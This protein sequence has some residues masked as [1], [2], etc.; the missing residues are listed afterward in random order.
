[1]SVSARLREL[2]ARSVA[3]LQRLRKLQPR[4]AALQ[5]SSKPYLP[6]LAGKLAIAT[7]LLVAFA[8]GAMSVFG[9]GSLRRLADA[10]GLTRVELAVSSARE[11]VRQSTEDLLQA[12]RILGER[13]ALQRELRGP[14]VETVPRFLG[15]Y[16]ESVALD[17]CAVVRGDEVLAA[18]TTAVD[19]DLVLAAGREQGERFLVTG[20]MESLAL[21]GALAGVA[22]HPG[23]TVVAL[24]ALDAELAARLTERTG[25]EIHI[26]DYVSFQPGEGPLAILNTDALSRGGAVAGYIEELDA[27][28][29]SL[30]VA[31][32]SGETIALLEARLP[33]AVVLGV[34][35]DITSRILFVA[36][37]IAAMAM[38]ISVYVGRYWISAVEGLTDAAERLA[39]GDLAASIPVGGG[40]ELTVLGNTM[41]LMRSNLVELTADLRR[42]EAEAKAVL[43]GIVEGVYAVDEERRVTFV[44]PQAERLLKISAA[45]ATGRFCGD[46][47]KPQLDAH[48]R[49]PCEHSCPILE[50][51]RGGS[52]RAV[53]QVAP[54]GADSPRRVVIASAPPSADGLQVQVLRDE[55]ELEAARRTRDTV[56]ANISHELRTPL[57]AQLASIELLRDGVGTMNVDGQRELVSSL[58]RGTQRLAWLIDNLLESVRIESGQLAIRHQDVELDDVIVAAR[59]LIEPLIAQRGQRIELDVDEALPTIRGDQQRLAQVLVNLLANANKFAPQGSVIRIGA[60]SLVV[61]EGGRGLDGGGLTFWVEDEGVAASGIEDARLFEQF[62]R[63]DGDGDADRD[64]SGLGLGLFIV[65]SIVERHG[66]TVRLERTAQGT[67]RATVELP[68]DAP[69]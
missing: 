63:V 52:G 24:R 44:N 42:S 67:T 12:A 36:V 28:A 59:D 11:G 3:G 48:G 61:P 20:A 34:A 7:G 38:A 35:G 9:I 33:A 1:M 46:V 10:E 58:H 68:Q 32:A 22:E 23:M 62:R 64:E 18:T 21:S 66:G 40:K 60:R 55:T 43:E 6:G 49:R 15:R 16:C 5:R 25:V 54:F 30:P 19:W 26:V 56:L 17:A 65:R 13:P 2:Y 8:V 69:A 4:L 39:A 57:A 27:Y 45:E 51:R 47:L 37:L 53:E 31:S 14:I 41:E 29:A 50:A